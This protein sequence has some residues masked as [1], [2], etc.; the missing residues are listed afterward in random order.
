M[1]PVMAWMGANLS[2]DDSAPL[3]LALTLQP[4]PRDRE[5]PA[6]PAEVIRE[7]VVGLNYA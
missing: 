4:I 2:G 7:L 3:T 5:D 1:T 6:C